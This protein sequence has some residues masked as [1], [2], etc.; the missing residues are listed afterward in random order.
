MGDDPSV[1]EIKDAILSVSRLL[2][3]LGASQNGLEHIVGFCNY[4][5]TNGPVLGNEFHRDGEGHHTVENPSAAF[6]QIAGDMMGRISELVQQM[7]NDTNSEFD[8]PSVA[9]WT[10]TGIL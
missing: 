3:Y 9:V 8:T 1:D 7:E 2:S 6:V 4:V 10:Y 5:L